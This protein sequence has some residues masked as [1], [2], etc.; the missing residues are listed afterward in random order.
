MTDLVANIILI[1]DDPSRA[2]TSAELLESL[3]HSVRVI[4]DPLGITEPLDYAAEV[5]LLVCEVELTR[6]SW[7]DAKDA[8]LALDIHVP[9]IMLSDKADADIM[10][11]A[12]RLGMSDYF[13]RPIVELE[14]L[15]DSI[16]RC[17]RRRRIRHELSESKRNLETANVELRQALAVLEQDQQAGRQVQLRMLPHSPFDVQN[18]QFRHSVHPS[19]YLSGDFIDY[20]T[21]GDHHVVFFMADVSGHGS[22]SAFATV[23]L[24]NL[25]ARKRSDFIRR[26][27]PMLLDLVA[28]LEHANKELLELGV[29]KYATMITGVIDTRANTLDYSV[30]GHLPLPILKTPTGADYLAGEGSPVGL[31]EHGRY[32]IQRIELPESFM[33]V[34]FS[35]GILDIIE[36]DDLI[37]KET[38]LRVIVENSDSSHTDL[39]QRLQL[40]EVKD[41]PDDIAA[42]FITRGL[43]HE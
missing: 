35:D 41:M 36:G 24:K 39:L 32:Q 34:I 18:Y 4:T 21:V 40:A 13:I 31:M 42:L 25:F 38:A 14:T 33:L 37:A 17:V 12:L 3:G 29:G 22:S 27:D 2:K 16:V 43:D 5:D 7:S 26:H 15:N 9:A 10:L 20:I 23:L 6:F 1:D 11:T 28:M 19:L 30:A 8:I